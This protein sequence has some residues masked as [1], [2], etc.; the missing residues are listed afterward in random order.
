MVRSP[1]IRWPRG[2]S[3]AIQISDPDQRERSKEGISRVPQLHIVLKLDMSEDKRTEVERAKANMS[4]DVRVANKMPAREL[5]S[6]PDQLERSKERLTASYCKEIR[7]VREQEDGGYR[8]ESGQQDGREGAHERYGSA[9]E[10]S[11]GRFPH[12]TA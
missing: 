4:E 11:R 6:H 7:H 9:R 12:P 10:E 3:S 5:I 1:G 2:S 8:Y